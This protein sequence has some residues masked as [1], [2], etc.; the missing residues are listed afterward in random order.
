MLEE[1]GKNSVSP[2][3][4]V[5]ENVISSEEEEIQSVQNLEIS[6]SVVNSEINR[7]EAFFEKSLKEESRGNHL[8]HFQRKHCFT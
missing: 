7:I 6:D 2:T 8:N 5:V 1:S 4:A 3:K